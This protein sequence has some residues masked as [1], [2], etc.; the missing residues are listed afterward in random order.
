MRLVLDTNVLVSGLIGAG[1]PPGRIV[2]LL[3]SG[4]A[5][6]SDP[7]I[8]LYPT[9]QTMHLLYRVCSMLFTS[10]RAASLADRMGEPTGHWIPMRGSS[11]RMPASRMGSCA[12][13]QSDE[14]VGK[15]RRNVEHGVFS[16]IERQAQPPQVRGRVAPQIH[17][18]IPDAA[19]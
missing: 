2:D 4:D 7:N 18:H 11:H 9:S 10:G 3:R 5:R 13:S 14:A 6:T 8:P 17:R 16:S 1:G 12:L 15:P 19:G